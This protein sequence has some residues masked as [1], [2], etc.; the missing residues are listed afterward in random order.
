[1]IKHIIIAIMV[2]L[3]VPSMAQGEDSVATQVRFGYLSYEAALT[4]MP[5]YESA[6]QQLNILREAY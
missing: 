6:R 1:M 3:A 2:L 5:E 4:A